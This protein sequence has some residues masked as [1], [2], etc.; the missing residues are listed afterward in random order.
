M[1]PFPDDLCL[2]T[3]KVPLTTETF[4]SGV[5]PPVIC[6]FAT[7]FLVLLPRTQPVR[8]V[9]WPITAILAFRAA[10]S[11]DVCMR[12]PKF[13][14]ELILQLSMICIAARTLEWTVQTK[15]FIRMARQSSRRNSVLDTLDLVCNIRGCGWDWSQGL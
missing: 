4:V 15:P 1:L 2:P 11:L 8:I 3:A 5:L 9:L 10:T 12:Q 13:N 14:V 7:A 6:S